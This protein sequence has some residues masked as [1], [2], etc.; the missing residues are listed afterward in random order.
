MPGSIRIEVLKS[1]GEE[2]TQT[3]FVKLSDTDG[4]SATDSLE[5]AKIAYHEARRVKLRHELARR[6]CVVVFGSARV[7]KDDMDYKF[8]TDLAKALVK[9]ND[10]DIATGGSSGIMEAANLGVILTLESPEG[11]NLKAKSIGDTITSLPSGENT[12]SSVQ[13]KSADTEFSTRIQTLLDRATIGVYVGPGGIG[14]YLEFLHARQ[15]EQVDHLERSDPNAEADPGFLLMAHPFWIP[16]E[17]AFN[18]SVY[19]NRLRHGLKPFIA[20]RDLDPVRY[21]DNIPEIVSWVTQRKNAR[22]QRFGKFVLRV[23]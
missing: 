17:K 16:I 2:I 20:E 1:I 14:T 7:D 13:I 21:S 5:R 4:H 15:L 6:N 9:S 11:A 18:E 19:H 3:G 23:P 22:N 10:V 12:N 8:I